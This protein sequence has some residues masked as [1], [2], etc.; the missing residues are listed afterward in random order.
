MYRFEVYVRSVTVKSSNLPFWEIG[1]TGSATKLL[2]GA[3]AV[4]LL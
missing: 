1:D 4:K 2:S 3:V